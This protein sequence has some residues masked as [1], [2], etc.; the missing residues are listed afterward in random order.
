M[1]LAIGAREGVMATPGSVTSG[2]WGPASVLK[3]PQY[4]FLLGQQE[5]AVVSNLRYQILWVARF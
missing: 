2:R 5:L 3:S 1:S 4:V